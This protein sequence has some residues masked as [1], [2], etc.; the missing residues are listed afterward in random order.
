MCR[1]R[2]DVS[3]AAPEMKCV[4]ENYVAHKVVIRTITD[5]QRG[6][7]LEIGCDVAGEANRRGI[8]GAALPID[9]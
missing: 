4:G 2:R 5:V 7:E 3:F 6:I 1:D 9:L 8:F